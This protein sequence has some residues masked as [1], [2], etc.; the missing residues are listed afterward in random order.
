MRI[1]LLLLAVL[2]ISCKENRESPNMV[3]LER[4]SPAVSS[5]GVLVEDVGIETLGGVF[6]PLLKRGCVSPCQFSDIF[7]TAQDNQSQIQ[8]SL[9]RGKRLLAA[10]NHRL[11][12]CYVVNIPPAPRGMI[13]VR[14][15]IEVKAGE[16][17]L[18]AVDEQSKKPMAIQCG[19]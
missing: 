8:L 2:L 18:S 3:V 6:T 9:F 17:R 13:L 19:G 1:Y 12:V 11:G 14:V 5:D 10:D 7:T 4:D 16:I 15:T